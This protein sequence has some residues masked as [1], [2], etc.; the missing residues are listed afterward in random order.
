MN[1]RSIKKKRR[2]N[3][4][5][6]ML[7]IVNS[8]IVAVA[9]SWLDDDKPSGEDPQSAEYYMVSKSSRKRRGG[10]IAV[11]AKNRFTVENLTENLPA[12]NE[13]IQYSRISVQGQTFTFI[14][15]EPDASLEHTNEMID[16][17]EK[18]SNDEI[19][20]GDLNF[21]EISWKQRK[22][23]PSM[24]RFMK[25]LDDTGF[26]QVVD[27]PTITKKKSSNTLDLILTKDPDKVRNLQI[28]KC[29]KMR[30]GSDH[31]LLT[32]VVN[33]KAKTE[34]RKTIYVDDYKKANFTLFREILYGKSIVAKITDDIDELNERIVEDYKLAWALAV[35]KKPVN[36]GGKPMSIESKETKDATKKLRKLCR[37]KKYLSNES[38][39]LNHEIKETSKLCRRLRRRD[40]AKE[41]NR[42]FNGDLKGKVHI[43]KHIERF[44]RK[45]HD[46]PGPLKVNG[47]RIIKDQEIANTF[48]EEINGNYSTLEI[49]NLAKPYKS[50]VKV[51]KEIVFKYKDIAKQLKKLKRRVASGADLVKA[52]MIIESGDVMLERLRDLYQKSYDKGT[53]PTSWRTSFVTPIFKKGRRE[54][55]CNYRPISVTSNLFKLMEKVIV[56][57]MNNHLVKRGVWCD[58]QFAYRVASG[59][60][61]SLISHNRWLEKRL[62]NK[63]QVCSILL[64]AKRAFEKISFCNIVRGLQEA[65]MPPKLVAWLTDTL[66]NRNFQ[67]KIGNALSDK[68]YP[69]SGVIQGGTCSPILYCLACNDS[70]EIIP[71]KYK[72]IAEIKAFADDLEISIEQGTDEKKKATEE[73]LKNV[74]TWTKKRSIVL[75]EKKCEKIN[76][77]KTINENYKL[78]NTTIRSVEIAR[79]LGCYYS[80]DYNFNYQIEQIIRK[81][82]SISIKIK[83]II[84][85]RDIRILTHIYQSA[86]A[87]HLDFAQLAWGRP[88]RD[89]LARLQ[90][91]QKLFFRGC[92]ECNSCKTQKR[93]KARGDHSKCVYH[94][95]PPP[96]FVQFWKAELKNVFDYLQGNF[97]TNDII[98]KTSRR[99][100]ITRQNTHNSLTV[101]RLNT[102]DEKK[103]LNA[104]VIELWNNLSP[105]VRDLNLKRYEFI[106]KLDNEVEFLNIPRKRMLDRGLWDY[107]RTKDWLSQ[108]ES[109]HNITFHK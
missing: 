54:E 36:I 4:F 65:G 31:Y 107:S 86:I 45:S 82:T 77:K 46:K 92:S 57:Q 67:V 73:I 58:H 103:R 48:K 44:N 29:S 9:E 51:M 84:K 21:R 13:Q 100:S 19:I 90:K 89:Q 43:M 80:K 96:V 70:G 108:L 49:P 105:N 75:N 74:E 60:N 17:I 50:K 63:I 66:V 23:P 39:M 15:R 93:K 40:L 7:S 41:E 37:K 8:D 104:R 6:H 106:K 28:D 81:M 79:N 10:G 76:Y 1:I 98:Y 18:A 33:T 22:W 35:P 16:Y 78:N 20:I 27:E 64:D 24:N 71:D 83:K 95:G 14:Y 11:V 62:D 97:R 72:H 85:T 56:A 101:L 61:N 109:S 94:H 3:K 68:A 12:K 102:R 32:F 53:I 47:K 88:N 69:S 99:D 38:I 52:A 25:V 2:Q 30:A 55:A 59:V 42:I 34:N 5:I 87:C 26:M 91:I